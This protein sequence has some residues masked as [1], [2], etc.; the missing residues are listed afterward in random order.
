MRRG[1]LRALLARVLKRPESEISLEGVELNGQERRE[2]E[3]LC[4]RLEQGEPLAYILG[5]VSF[6]GIELKVTKDVLIPRLETELLAEKVA[7][8]IAQGEKKEGRLLDLCAGS[9]AIG[10]SIKH[11]FPYIDVTL[12]DFSSEALNVAQENAL[13]NGLKVSFVQGD[14]LAPLVGRS[15]DYIVSNPPYIEEEAYE[16][17]E[18]SVRDY[19]PKIA[20]VAPEKGLHF[21]RRIAEEGKGFLRPGG[22]LFLEIGATQGGA[23]KQIFEKEGWPPLSIERDYSGH[24]RFGICKNSKVG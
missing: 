6:Y 2:F 19:E 23:V 9:G 16:R 7:A 21:Y 1:D 5:K 3:A 20:L 14:L 8:H 12:A 17:L 18:R 4:A 15:F 11:R 22:A 24:E 10:L 13:S